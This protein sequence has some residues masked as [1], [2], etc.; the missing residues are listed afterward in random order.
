LYSANENL[1]TKTKE[2]NTAKRGE[3]EKKKGKFPFRN[4]VSVAND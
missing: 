4:R 2:N 3:R 1:N